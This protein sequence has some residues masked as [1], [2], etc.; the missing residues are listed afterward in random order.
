MREPIAC[1]AIEPGDIHAR[2]QAGDNVLAGLMN[3]L[4]ARTRPGVVRREVLVREGEPVDGRRLAETE[5]V[6]RRL[7]IFREVSVDTLRVG[8]RLVARVVTHDGWTTSLDASL[9]AT[10]GAVTWSA[11]LTERN[12]LGMGHLLGGSYR[13]EVDRDAWRA[14]GQLNRVFGSR[15]AVGGYYDNLSDGRAA[16]WNVGFPYRAVSDRVE[17]ARPGRVA[18]AR[19]GGL[20]LVTAPPPPRRLNAGGA[21]APPPRRRGVTGGFRDLI[22]F[23]NDNAS[24][25]RAADATD[26]APRTSWHAFR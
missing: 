11:G 16:A 9:N 3:A 21:P 25:A 23:I 7:G 12:L 14:Q 1:V 18:A 8:N 4:H 5:R 24:G 13:K 22:S 6:L 19:P 2:A 10:G 20:G 26:S 15:A 17:L